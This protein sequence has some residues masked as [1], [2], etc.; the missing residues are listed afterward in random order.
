VARHGFDPRG[1]TLV[2][3]D[4][5]F[6]VRGLRVEGRSGA[7]AISETIAVEELLAEVEDLRS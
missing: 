4:G 7:I 1:L 6:L 3:I 5:G 2:E